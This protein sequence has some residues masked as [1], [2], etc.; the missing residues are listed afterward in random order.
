MAPNGLLTFVLDG[1]GLQ[2]RFDDAEDILDRPG[3]CRRELPSRV[4]VVLV[5]Q[6]TFSSITPS[7]H[8]SIALS[9]GSLA[10]WLLGSLASS[11]LGF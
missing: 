9:P 8:H 10:P 2:N 5:Y 4:V 3:P 6:Q 1:T 11:L 7:L